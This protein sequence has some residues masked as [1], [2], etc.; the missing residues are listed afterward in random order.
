RGEAAPV[1]RGEAAPAPRGEA[2]PVNELPAVAR[3]RAL[4]GGNVTL[5]YAS[6]RDEAGTVLVSGVEMLRDGERV[7]IETLSL[8]GMREDGWDRLEARNMRGS[9]ADFSLGRLEIAGAARRAARPGADPQPDDFSFD[10]ALIEAFRA[11]DDD[12]VL[13]DRLEVTGYGPGREV[14]AT[15][16]N[17]RILPEAR[18]TAD[19][20]EVARMAVSGFDLATLLG[21]LIRDRMPETLPEGRA[22]LEVQGV[23]V[24]KGTERLGGLERLRIATDARPGRPHDFALDLRGLAVNATN[25]PTGMLRGYGYDAVRADLSIEGRHDTQRHRVEIGTLAFGV[26]EA[27]ALGLGVTLDEARPGATPAFAGGRLR[28]AD[29][30]L[31]PRV[32]RSQAQQQRTTEQALREQGAAM[33][34]LTLQDR[35]GADLSAVR[36]PVLRFVRGEAREIEV[37]SRPER[38]I[39]Q[40]VM[41]KPP[42]DPAGWVRL[43]GLT[44]TAR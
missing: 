40:E 31:I 38:P 23:A 43:L 37:T 4:F 8:A 39:T 11:R 7:T 17:L 32:L 22:T 34:T 14:A 29:D 12:E 1:P 26:R 13:F 42:Q 16:A 5:R 25:G 28:Y 35:P 33:V 24:H 2:A 18:D 6:A 21:N 3:F 27:G 30:G 41:A 20:V 44:V 19:R 10:R 9:A 36:E 15:L